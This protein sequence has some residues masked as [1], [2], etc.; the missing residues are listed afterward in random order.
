MDVDIHDYKQHTPF[1]NLV[2]ELL[3]SLNTLDKWCDTFLPKT[4][5]GELIFTAQKIRNRLVDVSFLNEKAIDLVAET[6]TNP[7]QLI[8][9]NNEIRKEVIRLIRNLCEELLATERNIKTDYFEYVK[10]HPDRLRKIIDHHEFRALTSEPHISDYLRYGEQKIANGVEHTLDLQKRILKKI[11]TL[12]EAQSKI[13][14]RMQ[15][16]ERLLKQILKEV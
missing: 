9:K 8:R 16:N 4:K 14:E 3:T 11:E 15:K 6:G 5:E 10:L 2:K 7:N 13:V 1:D 12:T